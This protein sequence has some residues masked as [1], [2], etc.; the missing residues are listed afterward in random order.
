[1]SRRSTSKALVM[2]KGPIATVIRAVEPTPEPPLADLLHRATQVLD[3]LLSQ[4]AAM[5]DASLTA[6]QYA[7]LCAIA[8]HEGGSQTILTGA[9]SIDRSTLSDIIRRLKKRGWI[10]RQ[11]SR[12][13]SRAYKVFLTAEGLKVLS[14][15]HDVVATTEKHFISMLRPQLRQPFM[16]SLTALA[17][18]KPHPANA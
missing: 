2:S 13:D 11:K 17:Q 12:S 1:M 8:R 6:R 10:V 3:H 7:V 5:R 16:A 9:T 14:M 15:A 4:C 18:A